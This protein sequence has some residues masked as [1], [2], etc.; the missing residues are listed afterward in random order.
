MDRFAIE[1]DRQRVA[2]LDLDPRLT[3]LTRLDSL[4]GLTMP[5]G[6]ILLRNGGQARVVDLSAMTTVQD[7]QNAVTA[8]GIGARVEISE[9]GTRLNVRNELLQTE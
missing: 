8:L 9:D 4:S 7:L 1:V 5:L 6:Q 3:P 2:G